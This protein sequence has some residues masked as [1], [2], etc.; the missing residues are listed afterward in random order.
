MSAG[1]GRRRRRR[2]AGRPAGP[3]D[4]AD[5][6]P[7]PAEASPEATGGRGRS[8]RRRRSGRGASEGGRPSSPR[9]LEDVIRSIK[10][11]PDSLTA[12]PDGQRLEDVIG[13]LQSVWGVPQYPQ[14][15]RLLIKVAEDGGRA[16]S[17]IGAPSKGLGGV[18]RER[19]PAAPRVGAA[20]ETGSREKAP[21]RR[22]RSRRGRRG[23]G[24]GSGGRSI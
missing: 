16:G 10:G 5:Q 13:E 4:E 21:R 15:Y 11:T 18:T 3:T 17:Q 2:R 23:R 22:R 14:E 19:A 20:G 1:R 9:T 24:S 7:R 12:E 8:R 6:A